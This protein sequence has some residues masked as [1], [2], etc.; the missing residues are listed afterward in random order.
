M[1]QGLTSSR[2][3]PDDEAAYI[4]HVEKRVDDC[5][6]PQQ[7]ETGSRNAGQAGAAPDAVAHR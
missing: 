6:R 5:D 7:S 2:R 1:W 4:C 3:R